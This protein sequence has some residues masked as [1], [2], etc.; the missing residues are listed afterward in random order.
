MSFPILSLLAQV[1][2]EEVSQLYLREPKSYFLIIFSLFKLHWF[3][4]W[5]KNSIVLQPSFIAER[6]QGKETYKERNRIYNTDVYM[7]IVCARILQYVQAG[8]EFCYCMWLKAASIFQGIENAVRRVHEKI[9]IMLVSFC[10]IL[11]SI[12]HT[13]HAKTRPVQG[14]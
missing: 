13:C 7:H 6:Q 10:I 14:Q 5:K 4:H 3:C 11:F 9:H 2:N 1:R 12:C 8:V